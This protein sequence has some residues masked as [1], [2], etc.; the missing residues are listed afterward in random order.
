[1]K[2]ELM[3]AFDKD[4]VSTFNP[5]YEGEWKRVSEAELIEHQKLEGLGYGI[6]FGKADGKVVIPEALLQRHMFYIHLTGDHGPMGVA[7]ADASNYAWRI[8]ESYD[9]GVKIQSI[10]K[11]LKVICTYCRKGPGL[12]KMAL[13]MVTEESR[14][15]EVLV[16]DF[17]HINPKGYILVLTDTF[18]SFTHLK[19]TPKAKVEAIVIVFKDFDKSWKLESKS[20]S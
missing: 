20:H 1:M 14:P 16:S 18:S 17:L 8:P 11:E 6:Q 2:F 12:L 5:Y 9:E 3:R 15:R 19:Y 7:V 4:R 10:F 13:S